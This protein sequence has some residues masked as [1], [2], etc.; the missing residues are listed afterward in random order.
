MLASCRSMTKIAGSESGSIS[1]RHGSV[2]PDPEPHQNV[3]D[4]EHWLKGLSYEMD[5]AF[6]GHAWSVLGLNRGSG[7]FLSKLALTTIN[8]LF[9]L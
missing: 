8:K 3:T 7:L 9:A 4:P 1:Q 2:D 6:E 5:L